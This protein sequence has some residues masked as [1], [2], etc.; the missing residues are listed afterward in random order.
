MLDEYGAQVCLPL[1]AVLRPQP[2][3]HTIPFTTSLFCHQKHPPTEASAL[4]TT[5][6]VAAA[7]AKRQPESQGH[8]SRLLSLVGRLGAIG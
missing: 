7:W 4:T 8:L 5:S 1:V 2:S 3:L 6:Q